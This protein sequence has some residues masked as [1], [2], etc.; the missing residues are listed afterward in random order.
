MTI[1][2]PL[3]MCRAALDKFENG[4]NSLAARKFETKE[5]AQVLNRVSKVACGARYVSERTWGGVCKRLGLPSRSE[6]DNLAALLGRVEDR[7]DQLTSPQTD[8]ASA[9]QPSR[10]RRP[11]EGASA[12]ST[13]SKAGKGAKRGS[14]EGVGNGV[15]S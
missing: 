6:I 4:V 9:P 14:A 2:D 11:Q 7:I 5:F 13:R 3:R 8:A 12:K 15:S 1:L 10:T